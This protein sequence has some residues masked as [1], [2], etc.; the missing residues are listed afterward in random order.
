MAFEPGFVEKVAATDEVEIGTR[1]TNGELVRTIIWVVVDGGQVYVRS[2]EGEKGW[3]YRRLRRDPLGELHV[4]GSAAPVRAV[5][6]E[7]LAEIERVSAA[8][9]AK[10]GRHAASLARM[11]LPETLP[12]TLRLEPTA[13]ATATS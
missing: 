5:A 6:V 2:V 1:R 4:D 12:T 3:W 9:R 8:L 11:L 13:P 7:E 10:Y